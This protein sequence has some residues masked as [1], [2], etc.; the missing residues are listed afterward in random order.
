ME[1]IV[2]D[3]YR[4]PVI[5]ATG[6]TGAGKSTILNNISN[7]TAG[8]RSGDGNASVTDD[9]QMKEVH[10]LGDPN[11][12]TVILIDT[13]G[14]ED[15]NSI[16]ALFMTKTQKFLEYLKNGLD[17]I[18]VLVPVDASLRE[19]YISPVVSTLDLLGKN[20]EKN[21][22]LVFTGLNE[23]P[24][25]KRTKFTDDF[26][27]M[28]IITELDS[29]GISIK[30]SQIIFYD[31]SEADTMNL[32]ARLKDKI[33]IDFHNVLIPK[34]T[35][36]IL[37]YLH[38]ECDVNKNGLRDT[39]IHT[40]CKLDNGIARFVSKINKHYDDLYRDALQIKENFEKSYKSFMSEIEKSSSCKNLDIKVSSEH[41]SL[42]T[43]TG[44]Q[45]VQ[46]IPSQSSGRVSIYNRALRTIEQYRNYKEPF[47]TSA[48]ILQIAGK[49]ALYTSSNLPIIGMFVGLVLGIRR[50]IAG[51]YIKGL[52]ELTSGVTSFIPGVGTGVSIGID[53]MIVLT[54]ITE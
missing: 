50:F 43:A 17:I 4:K 44:N 25:Q 35:K 24:P 30:N 42:F 26:D 12:S 8:F 49:V 14:Y 38:L 2:Q 20:C 40:I 13:I 33:N 52:A 23:L 39:A 16:D 48:K 53:A 29:R 3:S 41:S 22:F 34:T 32:V 21:I 37:N 11:D 9:Y 54:D 7:Q 19:I 1:K 15:N 51:E 47:T 36:L 18:L 46:E 28:K 31:N 6:R 5:V 45:T 10:W 27:T